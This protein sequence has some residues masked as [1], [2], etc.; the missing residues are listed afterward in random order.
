MS[1]I[2]RLFKT[3]GGCPVSFASQCSDVVHELWRRCNVKTFL[4]LQW[5]AAF[6]CRG[7][8]YIVHEALTRA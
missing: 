5:R 7:G 2:S 3:R 8:V 6:D 4:A 1:R